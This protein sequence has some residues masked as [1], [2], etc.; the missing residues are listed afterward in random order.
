LNF[1]FHFC[2]VGDSSDS[3]RSSGASQGRKGR[4]LLTKAPRQTAGS[5]STSEK[6]SPAHPISL[7]LHAVSTDFFDESSSAADPSASDKERKE[8]STAYTTESSR[9]TSL[10]DK[11]ANLKKMNSGS[12]TRRDLGPLP[13]SGSNVVDGILRIRGT[14]YAKEYVTVSLRCRVLLFVTHDVYI[15]L[16]STLLYS[17]LLYSTLL[18]STLLYS[19]LLYSTLLYSTLLYSILLHSCQLFLF[20]ACVF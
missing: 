18:Y 12:N 6:S 13:E 19:T 14:F 17:T 3:W 15:V 4:T 2:V 1:F 7:A 8:N 11:N 20:S 16:Y 10:R 9:G 5:Q